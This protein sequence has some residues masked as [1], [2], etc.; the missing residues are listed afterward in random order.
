MLASSGS[1]ENEG[2][3]ANNRRATPSDNREG[4]R[5][6]ELNTDNNG[7]REKNVVDSI[8]HN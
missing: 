3:V 5:G 8:R 7:D 4:K 6:G 1:T 2:S